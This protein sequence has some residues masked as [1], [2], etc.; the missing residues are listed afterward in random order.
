[1]PGMVSR[2]VEDTL[3]VDID[4]LVHSHVR[5]RSILLCPLDQDQAELLLDGVAC[6]EGM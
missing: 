2:M 5:Y 3:N 1:M 6:N 4:V